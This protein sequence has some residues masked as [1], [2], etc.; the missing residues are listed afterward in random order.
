L[1]DKEDG[2]LRS[3]FKGGGFDP[4]VAAQKLLLGSPGEAFVAW[5]NRI[6]KGN[7]FLMETLDRKAY[8]LK[9]MR[10]R[11]LLEAVQER[12]SG[13]LQEFLLT[14]EKQQ[15]DIIAAV[16]AGIRAG[17]AQMEAE[18]RELARLR[19]AEVAQAKEPVEIEAERDAE[20]APQASIHGPP[21][22]PVALPDDDEGPGDP[23]CRMCDSTG[24]PCDCPNPTKT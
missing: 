14:L 23:A 19:A 2:G 17:N 5:A 4:A 20:A 12:G 6:Q 13:A 16:V 3:M 10:T 22:Q 18:Q 9:A 1:S 24:T 15:K 8:P 21:P 7:R 11:D